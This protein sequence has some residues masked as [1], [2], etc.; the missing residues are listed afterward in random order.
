MDNSNT[1]LSMDISA[2]MI[3][4]GINSMDIQGFEYSSSFTRNDAR[5][6]INASYKHPQ[7]IPDS[8]SERY[9]NC[10][11]VEKVQDFFEFLYNSRSVKPKLCCYGH[12]NLLWTTSKHDVYFTSGKQSIMHYS[13]TSQKCTEVFNFQGLVAPK[14]RHDGS[15]LQGFT[16]TDISALAVMD[17]YMV[18]GG[19]G[20]ELIC[21][22]LD[23]E[24]VSFCIQTN[25]NDDED[26]DMIISCIE[27][28]DGLRGGK[29]FIASC[30]DHGVRKYNLETFQEMHHFRFPWAVNHAS[31]SPDRRLTVVVGDYINGLIVDSETGET[32]ASI[33]EGHRDYF[34]T[35]AWHPESILFATGNRDRTCRVWDMRK[36]ISPLA[37]LKGNLASV[38]SVQFSQDGRFLVVAEFIDYVHIY[39]TKTDYNQRQEI[40]FNG[41]ITGVS[42]SPDDHYLYIGISNQSLLQYNRRRNYSYLDAY[43]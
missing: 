43:L 31:V 30:R 20:G 17:T 37:T 19:K 27:I 5:R 25:D 4:T 18:V 7:N 16:Q 40:D 15:L 21:K 22:R 13:S 10:K 28:Y 14:E 3:T 6:M 8:D 12:R 36:L 26:D 35:A 39:N 33:K 24:G 23:K 38:G 1:Q 41:S 34:T 42:L 29:S 2:A 32:V 11:E 9:H